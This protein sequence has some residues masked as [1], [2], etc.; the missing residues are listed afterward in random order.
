MSIVE[1]ISYQGVEAIRVGR[2]SRAINTTVLV[3]RVGDALIDSGPANQWKTLRGFVREKPCKQVILTHHHE[4]HSGNV[5]PLQKECGLPVYAPERALPLL[6]QGYPIQFYRRVV[7]G[8]PGL[9]EVE[10]IPE[11]IEPGGGLRLRPIFSPG[12]SPDMTCYLEP[13]RG[14]LFSGDLFVAALPRYLR[15]DEDFPRQMESLRNIL[16][17]EFA[18]LFCAHRGVVEKGRQ[19]FRRKLEYLESLRGRARALREQGRAV[20]EITRELLGPEDFLSWIS[21]GHFRKSNLIEAC[22]RD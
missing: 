9:V 6:A 17:Y 10:S 12:H 8:K 21:G 11:T 18:T 2:F 13:N 1:R 22:L 20:P 16:G 14:W 4:D 19:A 7:W 15:S 3:Y 5:I